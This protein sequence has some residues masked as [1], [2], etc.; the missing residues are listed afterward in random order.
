MTGIVPLPSLLQLSRPPGNT[1]IS[2]VLTD[3]EGGAT[4]IWRADSTSHT[5]QT[6]QADGTPAG[7]VAFS[8]LP[9]SQLVPL[10]NGGFLSIRWGNTVTAQRHDASGTPVG[11]AVSLGLGENWNTYVVVGDSRLPW[12]TPLS[13]GRILGTHVA[14]LQSEGD[15]VDPQ[16]R[17]YLRSY[18][19]DADG[20][21]TSPPAQAPNFGVSSFVTQG[22]WVY[23]LLQ[24]QLDHAVALPDGTAIVAFVDSPAGNQGQA[25]A[26][27]FWSSP[28]V[29][30]RIGTDGAPMQDV[31][32]LRPFLAEALP[33]ITPA[34]LATWSL[35]MAPDKDGGVV[36][37]I[38][39][40]TA[41]FDGFN[42]IGEFLLQRFDATLTPVGPPLS[43]DTGPFRIQM[44]DSS[45]FD[46]F[47]SNH[48]PAANGGPDLLALP[49]G[50]F[51][52]FWYDVNTPQG[53][54]PMVQR[55]SFEKG[56]IGNPT[57][58]EGQPLAVMPSDDQDFALLLS[59]PN[60][61]AILRDFRFNAPAEGVARLTGAAVEGTELLA[62]VEDLRDPDGFDPNQ[63]S[64]TWLRDG[65]LIEGATGS[66]YR[67]TQ[68][69]VGT[70]IT[71]RIGYIDDRGVE[72]YLETEP[73]ARI[74]NTNNAPEGLPVILGEVRIGIL[75]RVDTAMLR[76]SDG[77]GT[78][79]YQW[80]ADG[81]EI[82]GADDRLFL[83][84]LDL[85]GKRLT[86]E[87]SWTDGFGAEERVTSAP[88]DP[89]GLLLLRGSPLGNRLNG[90][91]LDDK[92]FGMGGDDRLYGL[93][94][95]DLLDGGAGLDR[96]FGGA[97]QDTLR[98]QTGNDRLSGGTGND[99]LDGGAGVDLVS[100]DA[101]ND[102]L[103]G[104]SGA[105]T[106]RGG[107]GDDL[108]MG[109]SGDDRLSGGAG[110][111]RLRGGAGNDLLDGGSGNDRLEGERNNDDLRGGAGNDT[112]SGGSGRDRLEGGT[113]NDR[114]TGGA[115][116]DVFV[117]GRG[118]GRDRITDF[119]LKQGDRV[120]LASD[121][122]TGTLDAAGVIAQFGTTIG[123][124]AALRFAG[125]ETLIFDRLA[126]PASLAAHIDILEAA[127]QAAQSLFSHS[128]AEAGS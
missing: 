112:L 29:L 41:Q 90:S 1:R 107:G 88:T 95:D 103:R 79:S 8:V 54:V 6:F 34:R 99:L 81:T 14:V 89:V 10:D 9:G 102:T 85:A 65:R 97:G 115:D 111:D 13:D 66:S 52:A 28:I 127:L 23:T 71:A 123:G 32:D 63:T 84:G 96:L 5:V 48:G 122:W 19:F 119:S 77:L 67:P 126:D 16:Q 26:P 64:W 11:E 117:F 43:F 83:P 91:I 58:I 114:L 69:D 128:A 27:Y 37:M 118:S 57:R 106:L 25:G 121:L 124:A 56:M 17:A 21:L 125:G 59:L 82:E 75:L 100:G 12:L 86:V 42:P 113:G 92:L 39:H 44:G 18:V 45:D 98:G 73:T 51:L 70:Q 55:F 47:G 40:P 4:V 116:A 94:G 53:R 22:G 2:R 50:E 93:E 46:N 80:F 33:D 72:E 61:E 62:S 49:N 110:A 7:S 3:D 78:I 30:Q 120:E 74:V 36:V 76:D 60:G 15:I 24:A 35:R 105:D 68:A 31:V 104:Q 101:G 38:L 109:G 87:V 20:T 108:L